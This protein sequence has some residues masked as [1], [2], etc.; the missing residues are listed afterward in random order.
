VMSGDAQLCFDAGM[1]DYLSKPI[2]L[3][4]LSQKLQQWLNKAE[5]TTLSA[6]TISNS[7]EKKDWDYDKALKRV[8]NKQ[9]LLR[10]LVIQF[11]TQLPEQASQLKVA[12][13]R[14]DWQQIQFISHSLKGVSAQLEAQNIHQQCIA[15]EAA[16]KLHNIQS[17]QTILV[18]FELHLVK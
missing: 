8:V 11:A 14:Q 10:K 4:T 6:A 3:D 13:E 15:L 1:D 12:I 2:S 5:E 7:T 16:A 17:I 18:E 9:K